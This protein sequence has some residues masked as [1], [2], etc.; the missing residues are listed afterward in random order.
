MRRCALLAVFA[1]AFLAGGKPAAASGCPVL[2]GL[3]DNADAQQVAR[4]AAALAAQ[5]ARDDRC[6]DA[7]DLAMRLA[8]RALGVGDSDRAVQACAFLAAG[9]D[10][11]PRDSRMPCARAHAFVGDVATAASLL[12]ATVA[13]AG[14]DRGARI[15]ALVAAARVLE[16]RYRFEAASGFLGRAVRESPDDPELAVRWIES[17]LEAGRAAE[18]G[19]AA[20]QVASRLPALSR[21]LAK[22]LVRRGATAQAGALATALAATGVREDLDAA[23]SI[24][25]GNKDRPAAVEAV[26]RFTT[27]GAPE[28]RLER[29]RV[30][31]DVL[32][33]QGL[34]REA[35]ELFEQVLGSLATAAA[36]D[37]ELLGTLMLRGDRAEPARAVLARA[38]EAAGRSLDAGLRLADLWTRHQAP[39]QAADVLRAVREVPPERRVE[40]ALRVGR[41]LRDAGDPDAE[42]AWYA[43]AAQAANPPADVWQGAGE[44]LLRAGD[45]RRAL[46]AFVRAAATADDA[47]RIALA[48]VGEAEALLAGGRPRATEAEAALRAALMAAGEEPAIGARIEA[49]AARIPGSTDLAREVLRAA[50]Q[51]DPGRHEPWLR[52]ARLEADSGHAQAALDA[53]LR[54]VDTA[55]NPPGVLS[56]AID[57]LIDAGMASEAIRLLD[58][59]ADGIR[60]SPGQSERVA[61][62]CLR[63]RHLRC[64]ERHATAFLDGPLDTD[65]DYVALARSLADASLWTAAERALAAAEKRLVPGAAWIARLERGRMELARGRDDEAADWFERAA[66]EGDAE[67]PLQ[68]ARAW[69]SSGRLA[70][71][72]PWYDRALAAGDLVAL[73]PEVLDTTVRAGLSAEVPRRVNEV[74]ETQWRGARRVIPV[75]AALVTLGL[76]DAARALVDTAIRALPAT[77]L[78]GLEPLRVLLALGSEPAVVDAAARD[79]AGAKGPRSRSCEM[80][81][82]GLAERGR[83][84]PALAVLDAVVADNPGAHAT[85]ATLAEVRARKG[86]VAGARAI[87][88]DLAAD[89][90]T[91][92]EVRERLLRLFSRG[93]WPTESLEVLEALV[94]RPS[95]APE[96]EVVLESVR[97]LLRAGQTPVA[98][99]RLAE[100]T[101]EAPGREFDAYRLLVRQGLRDEADRA[102][103]KAGAESAADASPESLAAVVADLLE[104]GRRDRVARLVADVRRDG[105]PA[106]IEAFASILTRNGWNRTALE[107]LE[108]IPAERRSPQGALDLAQLRIRSGNLAAAADLAGG[109]L[110]GPEPVREEVRDA[111]V[112]ALL[113]EGAPVPAALGL[114]G[115]VGPDVPADAAIGRAA[116]AAAEGTP[117]AVARARSVFLRRVQAV[118]ALPAS[119]GDYVRTEARLGTL[120]G[121]ARALEPLPGRPA[122]QARLHAA[123]LAGDS[124]AIQAALKHLEASD[125]SD[126]HEGRLAAA[127]ALFACGRWDAAREAAEAALDRMP[128][129]RDPREAATLSLIAG[130]LAG[131]DRV[132][133]TLKAL[134]G[135][136]DDRILLAEQEAAVHLAAGAFEGAAQ[137]MAARAAR[138]PGDERAWVGVSRMALLSGDDALARRAQA[139]ALRTPLDARTT[140]QAF[141]DAYRDALRDDLAGD[142]LDLQATRFPRDA[143]IAERR[144]AA[145]LQAGDDARALEAAAAVIAVSGDARAAA[146]HVVARATAM[147]S[148]PVI[149]RHLDLALAGPPDAT[150]SRTALGVALL[151][152]RTG[153]PDQGR[154]LLDRAARLA[155]D[156]VGL[157]ASL[158]RVAVADPMV[159]PDSIPHL[160]RALEAAGH[161]TPGSDAVPA[162]RAALCFAA[163]SAP[164]VEACAAEL[165]ASGFQA[166]PLLVAAAKRAVGAGRMDVAEA[167]FRAAARRDPSRLFGRAIGIE[168]L[169]AV[170]DRH[171]TADTAARARLGAFA[172]DRMAWRGA[173]LDPEGLP[174][175]AQ[176]VEMA[177]GAG[178]ARR[179]CLEDLAIHPTD[180]SG[181]NSL[182]YLLSMA[183]EDLDDALRFVRKAELLD[184]AQNGYYLETEG[185][186]RFRSGDFRGAVGPQTRAARLWTRDLGASLAES[187]NHLGRILEAV[188]RRDEAVAAYRQAAV[189]GADTGHGRAAL[190]NWV[191][192]V[193]DAAR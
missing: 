58:A 25:V 28:G 170:G 47:R 79:C 42:D 6:P 180:A 119:A 3:D 135:R 71:A 190:R 136:T 153:M 51:R 106:A 183:G 179:L 154:A 83:L 16:E 56:D 151:R 37:L 117:D 100:W 88:L 17:L 60:L 19:D 131:K 84:D 12:E 15:R 94:R 13:D 9:R 69:R 59:R 43:Q 31:V 124:A 189:R 41:A 24:H 38:F 30:G 29:A 11:V 166:I 74:P 72:L 175:A 98:L 114:L 137:A 109:V 164:G 82:T 142:L 163:A 108:G 141:E 113:Y 27:A 22:R 90:G 111:L 23:V 167:A 187:L 144:L 148:L 101:A 116:L 192:L 158:G 126:G 156:P 1:A 174:L 161:A 76:V 138:T 50:I 91:P 36:S 118:D 177:R 5:S 172:L 81:A 176:L 80:L 134:K 10:G 96:A 2:P 14:P 32:D 121:L 191:R 77:E 68:V 140:I 39:R 35:S 130:G 186:I 46:A 185:W 86:D 78:P 44:S 169:E 49:A 171:D 122:Q 54:A 147:L 123:C 127:R 33:R 125:G 64:A 52:L 95:G 8:E 159:P 62:A 173:A 139:Q 162:A 112:R 188:G 63:L 168:I 128:R 92:D 87:A 165:D 53:F 67:T 184:P 160:L 48:R 61:A 103:A 93:R 75:A 133:R 40:V 73:L 21:D 4:A 85:R 55:E 18:A 20:T 66:A 65:Y 178:E 115:P 70:R 143:T 34:A 129:D 149:D 102:I 132:A 145:A 7:R 89:A 97:A 182:A 193:R 99:A 181:W 105:S 120:A 104:H 157:I 110:G 152:F 146:I 150:A 155:T 107:L 45:E 57:R 26:R